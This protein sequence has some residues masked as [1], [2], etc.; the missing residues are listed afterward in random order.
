MYLYLPGSSINILTAEVKAETSTIILPKMNLPASIIG[1]IFSLHTLSLNG[2]IGASSRTKKYLAV[3]YK[4]PWPSTLTGKEYSCVVS[5][6]RI[7]RSYYYNATLL[8]VNFFL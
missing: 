4:I 3:K 6:L 7:L 1:V 5:P 8:A 2:F